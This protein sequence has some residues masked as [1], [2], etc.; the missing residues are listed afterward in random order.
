MQVL[1][2]LPVLLVACLGGTSALAQKTPSATAPAP[3]RNMNNSGLIA[4]IGNEQ[5]AFYTFDTRYEGLKGT[6]YLV[7]GWRP[8]DLT[9][10]DGR[11][12]SDIPARFDVYSK[13]L[14]IKQNK[15]SVWLDQRMVREFVL[16]DSPSPAMPTRTDRRFRAFP[17]AT[18]AELRTSFAELL[19]E[20]PQYALLKLP[21]KKLVKANYQGPYAADRRFDELIDRETYYLRRPDGTL[22]EVKPNLKGLTA[23]DAALGQKLQA[24]A[25][26]SKASGKSEAE[27][28]A[29]LQ[30]V[31]AK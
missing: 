17:D 25:A 18:D 2:F 14:V 1:R 13:R 4:N 11:A 15:D 9:L 19:H 10:S 29:L 7:S 3:E 23:V 21:R 16:H 27:L 22:V 6:P 8:A 12:F 31:D 5:N 26:R 30:A 24:E 28:V 20:G